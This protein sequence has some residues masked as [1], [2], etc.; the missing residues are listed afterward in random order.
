MTVFLN[1]KNH[2]KKHWLI[3]FL[4]NYV[5]GF[6]WTLQRN[7]R[8]ERTVCLTW[9]P[10]NQRV[11]GPNQSEINGQK[12]RTIAKRTSSGAAILSKKIFQSILFFVNSSNTRSYTLRRREGEGGEGVRRE[13]EMDIDHRRGKYWLVT[14]EQWIV[15]IFSQ[16]V[17]GKKRLGQPDLLAISWNPKMAVFNLTTESNHCE[18][19]CTLAILEM[20][21]DYVKLSVWALITRRKKGWEK[22]SHRE[23]WW[24]GEQHIVKKSPR[25]VRGRGEG[26]N[27]RKKARRKV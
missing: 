15:I 3:F 23:Q 19:Q 12:T 14:R 11:P 6:L 9:T 8:K 2:W 16:R 10:W 13:E 7:Y 4:R 1:S 25:N 20:Q 21:G 22:A 5:H 26:W 27:R 24:N 17:R 18:F